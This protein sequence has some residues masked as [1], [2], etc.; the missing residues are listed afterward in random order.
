MRFKKD[1]SR[2]KIDVTNTFLAGRRYFFSGGAD[3]GAYPAAAVLDRVR[4]HNFGGRAVGTAALYF[5]A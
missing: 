2:E 3:R 5:S 1:G 4:A